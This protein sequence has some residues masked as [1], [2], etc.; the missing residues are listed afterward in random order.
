MET[1]CHDG[2][3]IGGGGKTNRPTKTIRETSKLQAT[4]NGS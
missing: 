3:I 1:T 2:H 4:C